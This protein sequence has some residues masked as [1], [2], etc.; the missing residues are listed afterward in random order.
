MKRYLTFFIVAVM[1]LGL[2]FL[3][4]TKPRTPYDAPAEIPE[5]KETLDAGPIADAAAE[6]A[7]TAVADA[8]AAKPAA[9]TI[10]VATL[11]WELAAPGVGSE[12]AGIA[13]E[14]APETALDA[15]EAR[16]AKG[17]ADPAGADLAVMPLPAFVSSFE[18]LRALEPR[19]FLVVGFSRGREEI[20]AAQ[21]AL[22]KLPPGADEVKVVALAPPT[23]ADATARSGGSE[24]ATLTG[25]FALD[26]LGVAPTRVRFVAPGAAEAKGALLAAIVRGVTDERKLAFSTADA[27]RLVPIVAVAPKAQ[28]D[29]PGD[30]QAF[31]K[32]WLD[33][34][35]RTKADASGTARRLASKD[36]V[37]LAA[38]VGGAPEA[39][40]LV[41]RLGQI[42]G[43]DM[44]MNGALLGEGAKSAVTLETLTQR[45]WQLARAGGLTSSAAPDPLPIDGRVAKAIG[46][47]APAPPPAPAP[48][49]EADGGK[50]DAG[51]AFPAP[52]TGATAILVYR[53][54]A[55][56]TAE[57]VANQIAFL[58]GVFD[59]AAFRVSAKGGEKAA[60]AIATEAS[61]KH[62][63]ARTR[64]ATAN[65]EPAGTLAS[66]EILALP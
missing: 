4:F 16:L 29:K 30:A 54:P 19:A 37:R 63:I 47:V 43:A 36:G 64:L 60:R 14:I 51:A 11:G 52:P 57:T 58:A 53:A 34:L 56:A 25:L 15:I 22:L 32:A 3:L 12:D 38:G 31:A 13:L 62:A 5:P 28:L 40:A 7:V 46:V 17:G 10:R 24:S 1:T 45:T 6:A 65:A 18:R 20:H 41:D 55:D 9:K 48:A 27:S 26:L 50:A 59:R 35:A 42:E 21:G 33:G 61:D 44:A 39:I 2:V 8:G 49:P 23:A 66:V